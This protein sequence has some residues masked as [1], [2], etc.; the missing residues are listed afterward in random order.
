MKRLL[1]IVLATSLTGPVQAADEQPSLD[2]DTARINYSVGYQIGSDFKRQEVEIRPDVVVQGIMDALSDGKPLLSKAE[3]NAT[4]AEMGKRVAEMRKRLAEEQKSKP[5]MATHQ[6]LLSGKKF[7]AENA[8]KEGVKT[9]AS[10]LQYKVIEA[11]TGRKPGPADTVTVHYRG[12][13]V[14][15]K[16]FDSSY[17]RG[18][19]ATFRVDRVIPGWTEALLMMRE[20]AKWQIFLPPELAYGERGPMRDR[21]MIFDVELIAVNNMDSAA[22]KQ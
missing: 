6:Y 10:G 13:Q 9:T 16:E 5:D 11:G 18:Q 2:D 4:M 19:P 14:D 7:L 3:M 21:A 1:A 8:A 20:G 17:R 12:T 22:K 15:G